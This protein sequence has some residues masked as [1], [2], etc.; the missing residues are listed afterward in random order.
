MQSVSGW[1]GLHF[2]AGRAL[3]CTSVCC[4]QVRLIYKSNVASPHTDRPVYLMFSKGGGVHRPS[5][6]PR[7]SRLGHATFAFV[8]PS[9]S[10]RWFLE[11]QKSIFDSAI[12]APLWEKA[13]TLLS[14]DVP[15]VLSSLFPHFIVLYWYSQQHDTSSHY[16]F[17]TS[18]GMISC[19]NPL[20]PWRYC[21]HDIIWYAFL[22]NGSRKV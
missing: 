9:R 3:G 8:L 12:M 18:N 7:Q 13:F 5:V 4:Q 11:V 2:K 20:A 15:L 1:T 17:R 21:Q 16:D 19:D 14:A 10:L 6:D 22:L